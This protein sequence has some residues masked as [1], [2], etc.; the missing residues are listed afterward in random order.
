MNELRT[1]LFKFPCTL[2]KRPLTQWNKYARANVDDSGW[3]LVGVLTGRVSGFDCLDVDV[4]GLGWLDQVRD[5]LPP[6]RTHE[7]RSGGRH[8]LWKHVEGVRNSAGRIA[9]G[10]D[11]RGEGGFIVWWP[12]QGLR[13]L[14]D[15]EIA[16][17]P[18]WLLSLALGPTIKAACARS[19]MG[20]IEG[21]HAA[22]MVRPEIGERTISLRARSTVIL[23]KVYRAR[24]GER[25]RLLHWAAC[26][27]GEM[28]IEGVIEP[29][30]ASL[31]LEG[32]AMT[33]GLWRDDGPAQCRLTI[34]SGI[35]AGIRDASDGRSKCNSV[36]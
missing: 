22:L 21:E 34:R 35:A 23:R 29:D 32:A 3:P 20:G 5:K 12:R 1:K 13:V 30:V 24:V 14:N 36:P 8:L 27:F 33:C 7:T 15:V 4:E 6:T 17:W 16:E 26:R 10:V 28:I 11:V 9:R 31:L 18:E 25:N 2:E 19:G